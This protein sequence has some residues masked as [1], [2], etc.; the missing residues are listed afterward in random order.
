MIHTVAIIFLP[1]LI[2]MSLTWKGDPQTP[3]KALMIT[4]VCCFVPTVSAA[5]LAY[6][7]KL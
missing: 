6:T 4:C 7:S 2:L 3:L 1:Q 5:A